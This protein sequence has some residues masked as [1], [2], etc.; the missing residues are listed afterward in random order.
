MH[1]WSPSSTVPPARSN[2]PSPRGI[3][4]ARL[5]LTLVGEGSYTLG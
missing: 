3:I 2:E 4:S 1:R 5:V